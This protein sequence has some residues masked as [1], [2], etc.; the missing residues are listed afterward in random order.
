MKKVLFVSRKADKCGVAD[1]GRRVNEIL[2]KSK[3]LS[4]I[5]TEIENDYE[6]INLIN[7]VNPDVVLYNYYGHILP[8]ITDE[9]L[10]NYRH[11]PHIMI[12]HENTKFFTPTAIIDTDST[13]Q[14][15]PEH[16]F[17]SSPRPLFENI[18]FV[19]IEKNTIPTIGSFG[20]GFKDK[21]FPKIAEL[22]CQQF[23]NAKIRL[24]IP[25]ATFGDSDGSLALNEVEK[26]RD[27]IRN[28]KKDILLEVSHDFLTHDE[29][30]K[31]LAQNDVNM[32]LYDKHDT[33]GL[34]STIDY[35]L[36]V[37]KPIAINDSY[38]FRHINNVTPSINVNNTSIKEIIINGFAPLEIIYDEYSNKNFIKKYEAILTK[39]YEK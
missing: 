26:I 17:Y 32:F 10:K 6:Y 22:V 38:M 14:D 36:S 20:F 12:Y 31:F 35:S 2:Q 25:F 37:K 11:I 24:N 1:Y 4:I 5:W 19:D 13:K 30:L 39:N 9:F 8:F 34:S 21:N 3:M 29:I 15:I 27:V 28:Y 18:N 23:N 33:R 7:E 16:N